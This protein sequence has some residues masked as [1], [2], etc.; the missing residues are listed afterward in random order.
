VVRAAA[1]N[2]EAG[3]LA[4][5]MVLM[6]NQTR[7]LRMQGRVT[8]A[9]EL[10]EQIDRWHAASAPNP[11]AWL[12]SRV[13]AS[14]VLR[15]LGRYDE[16]LQA[17]DQPESEMRQH[18]GPLYAAVLVA[19]AKVWLA[20]GQHTRA[21]Q[22]LD[23]IGDE[24]ADRPD[25]LRAQCGLIAAQVAARIRG[26]GA[27]DD[28]GDHERAMLEA[29]ARSAPRQLRRSAW[30]ECELQRAQWLDPDTGAALAESLALIAT[31]HAMLGH[32]QQARL[33]EAAQR[34]AA[35]QIDAAL[36]AARQAQACQ[37]H[38]FGDTAAAESVQP[39]GGSVIERDLVLA[40]VLL[41][42]QHSDARTALDAAGAHL[43]AV[44]KQHV[45]PEFQDSFLHR[46]PANCELLTLLQGIDSATP[47]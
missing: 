5:V 36:R 1:L 15:E 19:R 4:E 22:T 26:G 47:R 35:G 3:D 42:A 30:L 18:L 16:A 43:Q 21:R 24:E 23:P 39:C 12:V 40:R 34:L 11:R 31:H 9:Q 13:G 6:C 33:C 44:L 20:L 2:R 25:W 46:N 8:A 10:F 45:P 38:R 7:M 37:Q 28:P 32:A 17:L 41:A 14:E 27:G 29:A